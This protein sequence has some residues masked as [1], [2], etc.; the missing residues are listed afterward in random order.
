VGEFV[1]GNLRI[2]DAGGAI[3][4]ETGSAAGTH[5]E[6]GNG[7]TVDVH[8][9]AEFQCTLDAVKN[10]NDYGIEAALAL[11][12]LAG[13]VQ[14]A[15]VV[16]TDSVLGQGRKLKASTIAVNEDVFAIHFYFRHSRLKTECLGL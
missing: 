12:F 14:G 16:D 6:D 5:E 8:D 15:G 2:E 13:F 4:F 7:R 11:E 1:G 10:I 9:L 3:G